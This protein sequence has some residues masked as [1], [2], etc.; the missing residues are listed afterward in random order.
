MALLAVSLTLD[1]ARA[2]ALSARLGTMLGSV[3]SSSKAEVEWTSELKPP[4]K[5]GV[6]S[7]QKLLPA[8]PVTPVSG[9]GSAVWSE[10]QR[11]L[12]P[13]AA[14][15]PSSPADELSPPADE[16]SP[17]VDE[18]GTLMPEDASPFWYVPERLRPRVPRCVRIRDWIDAETLFHGE[19]WT[20][21]VMPLGLMYRSYLAGQKESRFAS[22]LNWDRREGTLWDTA[23]GGRLGLLRWGT[24][25]PIRP[26]GWQIDIEGGTQ[27]RLDPIS[28]SAPLLSS[29][30]RIGVPITWAEG[31]WQFKTGYYHI[32][33]HLGDEYI[34]MT[35]PDELRRLN[36]VRD[37]WML[38][39]GY[40]WTE[41]LR[42]Y[43]ETAYAFSVDDGAEPWEFQFGADWAPAADTGLRGAPF[44][45]LNAHLREEVD[46]GG[47]W[48]VQAGWAWRRYARGS[49]L[50]TGVQF[51]Q[52]KSDQYEWYDR[53]ERRIGWGVWADF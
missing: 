33:A 37:A 26:E 21:Q 27:A 8:A 45:A 2:D 12:R 7:E 34:L 20:W 32:S 17:P 9:P 39:L 35:D 40:Y 13:V 19:D 4:A 36:Y 46:F 42:L 15:A 38:A 29:D 49:L 3:A 44:A 30:F 22:F 25:D 41:R 31:P 23:L 48:V 16:L 10:P 18:S 43:A 47:H 1:S 6:D 51:F 50:R 14:E 24:C 11:T 28:A 52:G 53:T 5:V